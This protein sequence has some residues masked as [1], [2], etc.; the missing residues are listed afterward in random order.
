M[1]PRDS[2]DRD[3]DR[4]ARSSGHEE[5]RTDHL[6]MTIRAA[7]FAT[8]TTRLDKRRQRLELCLGHHSWTPDD[9]RGR[10]LRHIVRTANSVAR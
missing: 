9:Q 6:K 10:G 3:G 1:V 2:L 4:R 7:I 5:R 8:Q